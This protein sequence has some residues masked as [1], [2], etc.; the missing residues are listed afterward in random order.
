MT[1]W[2]ATTFARGLGAL[3]AF[4][5]SEPELSAR[6]RADFPESWDPEEFPEMDPAFEAWL[7]HGRE[8][9]EGRTAADRRLLKEGAHLPRAERALL[10]ALA[11]SWCSV[12]EVEEVRFGAGLRL[13]DLLLDEVLEVREKSLTAQVMAHDVVVVWVMPVEDHLELVGSAVLIPL[14]L[15]EQ[16]VA[17]ARQ[18]HTRLPPI[19]EVTGRRRQ[20]RRL[21]PFLFRH[22]LELLA[23]A[24][25]PPELLPSFMAPRRRAFQDA[26]SRKPRRSSGKEEAL[27]PGS[28]YVFKMGPIDTNLDG[29][30]S[31]YVAATSDGELIPPVVG[32]KDLEGLTELAHQLEGRKRYCESRLARAGASLGFTSR[33]M[34]SALAK[35]R[36][37]LAVQSYWGPEAPAD[38]A[39]ELLDLLLES[40]AELIRA[41]PWERWTN[42]EVFPVHLEGS[43]RGTRE[44]SVL[45][46]GESEFGFALFDRPGSVE[47]LA[48]SGPFGEKVDVLV[49]DSLGLT[50]EDEPSWAVKSVQQVTGLPFVPEVIRVERNTPRAATEEEVLVAAA[51]TRA[52]A[53]ARP[54]ERE[55]RAELRVGDLHVRVRLEVPL[56][57]LSGEYAGKALPAKGSRWHPTPTMQPL[58]KLP[59]RK[60]SETLLEFARPLLEDAAYSDDMQDELFVIL[61]LAMSAWNAVV[62]DT[63][64]PEKGWVERARATLLR[65]PKGEREQMTR[66]FELLVERK[67]RHFAD[68]P[69]VFDALD[70]VVHRKGDLGVRLMG[71]VTPG[72][73][74]EFLGM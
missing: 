23:S 59:T 32:R 61:A 7:L 17:A 22:L 31:I 44:L 47:R 67:R 62:Q 27:E 25:P 19:R 56:P 20:A 51:V 53:S 48:L 63:W 41:E 66:D 9:V 34:P 6:A 45:G 26:A 15:R 60:V 10:A 2:S 1:T 38:L 13:R 29:R 35:L 43:M 11:A 14:P 50:L 39:P 33:R 65:M 74:D 70:V 24:P 71:M 40:A 4:A 3:R 57:L 55:A 54:E 52:L 12:F 49:P 58:H 28:A 21:A 72:A 36:A 46:G 18:E 30:A 68:D 5:E 16:F 37:V 64:E 73:W 69:R 42:E 8:D